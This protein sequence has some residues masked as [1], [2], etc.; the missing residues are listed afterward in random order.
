MNYPINPTPVNTANAV[1]FA[2]LV[3][4]ELAAIA[5]LGKML[6]QTFLDTWQPQ[7][8]A[9]VQGVV[10][11]CGLNF[12]ARCQLHAALGTILL[13]QEAANGVNSNK[14]PWAFKQTDG[15]YAPGIPPG[16]A[17]D[18]PMSPQGKQTG[19][20]KVTYTQPSA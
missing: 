8:P 4:D 1:A 9:T 7:A 16:W 20:A 6:D 15:S 17:I 18:V 14:H 3:G 12:V 11:A 2:K 10:S 5:N 19:I 13:A